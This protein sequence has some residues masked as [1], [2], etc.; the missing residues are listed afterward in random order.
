VQSAVIPEIYQYMEQE[1]QT[2]TQ[3]WQQYS[4]TDILTLI[5]VAGTVFMLIRFILQYSSL[6]RLHVY[7]RHKYQ[8]YS[9]LNVD[10]PIKPFS[11]G[12]RI[13]INPKLHNAKELDEIIRHELIHIHQ[14]HSIDIV[15]AAINNSI[16]WWN[17]FARILNGDI[18][19][20]LEYIVDKEM[21][22][23][24]TNRKHY[25][26]HLLNINQL[27]YKNKIA[28]YFNFSNI[29]KRIN[30]MNKEK[31]QPVYKIK[32]LLLPLVAAVILLSFNMK[33]AIATN[34]DF[35][36]NS[37]I[38][39]PEPIA[40][41][42]TLVN[43]IPAGI[44]NKLNGKIVSVKSPHIIDTVITFY[45]VHH[46]DSTPLTTVDSE[47]PDMNKVQSFS[48]VK[49]DTAIK[50]YDKNGTSINAKLASLVIINGKES[51]SDELSK[52]KSEEIHSVTVMKNDA[53]VKVYGEKGKN[54]VFVIVTK[55][56]E[57]VAK[58]EATLDTVPFAVVLGYLSSEYK[59]K[60]TLDTVPF[61]VA[62]T[63]ES[64]I[65]FGDDAVKVYDEN[66]A[67]MNA[68]LASLIIINEQ[69]TDYDE[70]SKLKSEE[71]HSVTVLKNDAAVKVYGEKAKNGVIVIVT[72]G[73]EKVAKPKAT[74]DIV[75]LAVAK[76]KEPLIIIDE[77][78]SSGDELSKLDTT[79][80]QSF[81]VLKNDA[82]IKRY[83]EKGK[84][85]VIIVVT[86]ENEKV[87]KPEATLDT[88]SFILLY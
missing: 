71:I 81:S 85:G 6:A 80:I 56:N 3:W 21:L 40:E 29:K 39:E 67:F 47:A 86:T 27:I 25:Q 36:G 41:S 22:Q 31:T 59:D 60:T 53:A 9:I 10:M 65:T 17:P 33:R 77:K 88:V 14:Y 34:V 70:L 54:G 20:N 44:A 66:G 76:N 46:C 28:N 58:P 50:V 87:A 73:N 82:A 12:K 18:R 74:L 32:W 69:K 48:I 23:N 35:T 1:P 2:I 43:E 51:S 63:I 78:E 38:I 15:L 61:A 4:F 79:K 55:G 8:S 52:L 72:K 26:Y 7:Q 62:K 19:N 84:N 64:L 68:K 16:F 49:N 5:F 37:E 75:P 83:G 57:K 45:P 24:G 30:M 13:Y 11:Y 42:D